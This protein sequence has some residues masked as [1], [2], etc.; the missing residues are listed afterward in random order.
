M[1]SCGGNKN[2]MN[3]NFGS[4][5]GGDMMGPKTGFYFG[6]KTKMSSVDNQGGDELPASSAFGRY[7]FGKLNF[8]KRR[9][10][11]F[12]RRRRG[13]RKSRK[14]V[15]RGGRKVRVS[16]ALVR[17]CKK[18]GI[19]VTR[20]VGGKRVYKKTAVL[21][22]LLRRKLK[23]KKV[24]KAKKSKKHVRRRHRRSRFSLFGLKF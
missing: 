13:G 5:M 3:Y 14:S 22:K 2:M 18:H 9:R 12:G 20:K 6:K 10:T 4:K 16:K 7:Y 8:G 1:S 15:R 23:A 21:K 19:K 11:Y 24:K 17:A